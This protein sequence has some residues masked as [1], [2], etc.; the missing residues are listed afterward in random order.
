M[1]NTL[2]TFV[3]VAFIVVKVT[4]HKK[5]NHKSFH[6]RYVIAA[7]Q[8][9]K[10]RTLLISCSFLQE[11]DVHMKYL[12]LQK[13]LGTL[14]L[15]KCVEMGVKPG[16]LLGQLKSG[17]DVVLPDGRLV[18]SKDVKTPDDP[19]PVF[20]GDKLTCNLFF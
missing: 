8:K 16:P 12:F 3:E 15:E 6:M 18:L 2:T 5:I 20:I 17:H 10:E 11:Y 19:G 7:I 14:D 9:K 4:L 13:R 1:L